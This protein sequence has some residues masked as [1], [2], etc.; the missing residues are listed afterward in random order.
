M[1][2]NLVNRP[3]VR[4]ALYSDVV[5]MHNGV[6]SLACVHSVTKTK[7]SKKNVNKHVS[8]HM[9]KYVTSGKNVATK[10]VVVTKA[11]PKVDKRFSHFTKGDNSVNAHCVG[12]TGGFS[13][14]VHNRFQVLSGNNGNIETGHQ[15]QTNI[16]TDLSVSKMSNV[17]S[18][19]QG[20]K[21]KK[22]VVDKCKKHTVISSHVSSEMAKSKKNNGK[23]LVSAEVLPTKYDMAILSMARKRELICKAKLIKENRKVFL[24]IRDTIGFIPVSPLPAPIIDRSVDSGDNVDIISAHKLLKKDGRPNYRGLQIPVKSSLNHKN[25][26]QYLKDYWDWQLPFFIKFGFPLDLQT[27]VDIISTKINHKSATAN[28]D[29]VEQYI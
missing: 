14:P 11:K 25:F 26:F 12:V 27:N 18:T 23:L 16:G 29:H 5:R 2:K 22:H 7:G 3:G 28:P 8:Q 21:C 6:N 4:A 13:T 24:Q 1:V 20:K 10:K 19:F 15:T 17:D 9:A